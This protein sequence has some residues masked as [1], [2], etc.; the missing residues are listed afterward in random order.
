MTEQLLT[1]MVKK[2]ESNKR[3]GMTKNVEWDIKNQHKLNKTK[4]I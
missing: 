1:G 3:H 4:I 2:I